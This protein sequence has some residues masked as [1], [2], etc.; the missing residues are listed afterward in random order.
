LWDPQTGSSHPLTLNPKQ[1][2]QLELAPAG[3]AL[4]VFDPVLP[5]PLGLP[6]P[7]A[8]SEVELSRL[9]GPWQLT[10]EPAGS[11]ELIVRVL[12]QLVDFSRQDRDEQLYHFGGVATYGIDFDGTN[13]GDVVLDLGEVHS[14]SEVTLNGVALGSRWW[15]LHRYPLAGQLRPGPNHLQIKVST[16][17][18]NQ[19]RGL[20]GNP[21]AQRWAGWAPP[22]PAGLA[23]PV[24][25]VRTLPDP[26]R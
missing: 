25:L 16:M 3:S 12:P 15:G 13:L 18:A 23:G 22:I 21:V 6:P 19:M 20:T 9:H 11:A 24:R 4:V 2:V 17:L 1:Q 10:L 7:A 14:T 8:T 5:P 26:T